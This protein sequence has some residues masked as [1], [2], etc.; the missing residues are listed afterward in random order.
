MTEHV[1]D[2]PESALATGTEIGAPVDCTASPRFKP[3]EAPMAMVRTTPSPSCC[4]TSRVRSHILELQRLIDLRDRLAR[5]LDVDDGADD[6]GN[7]SVGH[8]VIVPLNAFVQLQP[9]RRRSPK[10]LS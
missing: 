4:W 6:L 7:L 1:H 10:A 9:R 2:A 3:S 8:D 5:K